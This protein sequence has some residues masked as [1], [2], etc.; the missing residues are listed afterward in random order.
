MSMDV[1]GKLFQ[2]GPAIPLSVPSL[3]E[4]SVFQTWRRDLGGA[5]STVASEVSQLRSLARLSEELTSV[6]LRELR[7]DPEAAAMLI[8]KASK[9]LGMATVL[10]RIRA[11][12]RFLMM[13]V[14]PYLG[15]QR[16]WTFQAASSQESGQGLVRR[17]R[18]R[19][20]LQK[21]ATHAGSNTNCRRLGAHLECRDHPDPDLRCNC[22]VGMF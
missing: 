1:Q 5:A 14:S 16:V 17:G 21:S 22:C 7:G 4:L 10:T 18:V 11:F 8:E 2:P 9:G 20:R 15:R 19:T 13:G 3:E 6:S 12:Q